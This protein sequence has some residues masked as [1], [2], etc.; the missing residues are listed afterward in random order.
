[1]TQTDQTQQNW[2]TKPYYNTHN[3]ASRT[4]TGEIHETQSNYFIA[5]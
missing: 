3:D 4:P 2:L 5:N 1:M